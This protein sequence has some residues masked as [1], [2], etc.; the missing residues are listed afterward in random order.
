LNQEKRYKDLKNYQEHFTGVS[1]F[2]FEL[3]IRKKW[4][5]NIRTVGNNHIW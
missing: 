2:I 1:E 3:V 5:R 4:V